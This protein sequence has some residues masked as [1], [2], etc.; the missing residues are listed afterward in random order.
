MKELLTEPFLR[1]AVQSV[2]AV[3]PVSEATLNHKFPSWY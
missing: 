1:Q 2:T 3:N